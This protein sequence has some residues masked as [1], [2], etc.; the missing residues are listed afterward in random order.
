MAAFGRRSAFAIGFGLAAAAKAA[1]QGLPEHERALYDAA[2]REGELTW[3][4]GQFSA[5]TSE[6]VGRA[7]TERYPGV[8]VNVTR[9][10]S[11]VAYQRLAQDMRARTAQC[12]IFAS[13]NYGHFA[14]LKR[15]EA[16]LRF[17]PRNA[18]GLLESIRHADAEDFYQA[19]YIG[20]YMMA[21]NTNR[22]SEADAPKAWR[23]ALDP[24][25]RGQLAVGHPGYS[26]AIGLWAVQM[27]KMFTWDYFVQLERNR[28]MIGRSSQDPI[29]T[30][31]AGE[32]AVAVAA[33][34]AT[35]LLSIS[36]GNPLKLIYPE[37]G[38]LLVSAPAAIL[39]NAPHPNAAKLFQEF[40]TGPGY[41]QVARRYFSQSL[42]PDVPPP[43]GS[44]PLAEVTLIAPTLA[45]AETGVPEVRERWRDTFG[46]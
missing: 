46:V 22:V 19:S 31:N 39:H 9:S 37:D 26:G 2:Q 25:W 13:T 29:T 24:R 15:Q 21:F 44:R 8:R 45:E 6:A 35:T 41:S 42:R 43:E 10:T 4:T 17:R 36:R 30:L 3:Y 12:D 20:L 11:Q 1:A 33:P 28:P 7:F 5:E 32:R 16:L 27:R 23:D 34:S 14:V 18:D 40:T 38:T